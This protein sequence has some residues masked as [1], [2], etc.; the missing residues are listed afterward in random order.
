MLLNRVDV[1]RLDLLS[2]DPDAKESADLPMVSHVQP[3]AGSPTL[4]DHV[5]EEQGLCVHCKLSRYRSMAKSSG[6]A[7]GGTT[8]AHGSD[9]SMR[10]SSFR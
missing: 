5:R 8:G 7:E 10:E 9:G 3:S 4:S 6:K 1:L 2:S